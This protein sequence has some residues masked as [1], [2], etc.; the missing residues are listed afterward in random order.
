M[1]RMIIVV[2][3][4]AAVAIYAV[5]TTIAFVKYPNAYSPLTN[6]LNDLG[7]PLA[8]QS[9]AIFYNLGC[10]LS[11]LILIAFYL[12][13]RDWANGSKSLRGLLTIAQIAGW[14]SSIFF[15]NNGDF[16]AWDSYISP[17]YFRENT[18]HLP[19]LLPDL[20][21]DSNNQASLIEKMAGLF[22]LP[23]RGN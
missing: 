19:W 20:L 1:R 12:G 14:L 15:G 13:L 22:W 18:Y 2:A 11:G 6:W 8:N 3:G 16:P 23:D 10:I 7:N 9:G 5:F 17:C 4:F 21:S